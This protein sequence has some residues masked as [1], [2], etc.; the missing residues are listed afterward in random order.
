MKVDRIPKTQIPEYE[1]PKSFRTILKEEIDRLS[2][3]EALRI[4][5]QHHAEMHTIRSWLYS[6]SQKIRKQ[7]S[8]KLCYQVQE[9]PLSEKRQLAYDQCSYK[10]IFPR[11]VILYTWK[12]PL[13]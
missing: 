1:E 7:Q 11:V 13:K 10:G 9:E 12:E 3:D 5:C 2:V 6:Y 4:S 8:L